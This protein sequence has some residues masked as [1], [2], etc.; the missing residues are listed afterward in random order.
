MRSRAWTVRNARD[1]LRDAM[2]TVDRVAAE[3]QQEARDRAAAAAQA[4]H[5]RPKLTRTDVEGAK[6]VR[7]RW[8]WHEVVR[9]NA[10]TVTVRTANSWDERIPLTKVLE[11]WR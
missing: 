1:D 5:D 8:G 4:E 11:A 6:H 7:D 9:V 2:S 10:A 3:Q